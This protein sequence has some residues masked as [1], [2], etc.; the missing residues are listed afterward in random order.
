MELSA[1][2]IK[3]SRIIYFSGIFLLEKNFKIISYSLINFIHML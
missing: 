2:E 1:I 3:E